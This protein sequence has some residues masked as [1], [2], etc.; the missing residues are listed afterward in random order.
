MP[1]LQGLLD[2]LSVIPDGSAL[3]DGRHHHDP[4]LDPHIPAT[5]AL[6]QPS[7]PRPLTR[8]QLHRP[9]FTSHHPCTVF[10]H[11]PASDTVLGTVLGKPRTSS[12]PTNDRAANNLFLVSTASTATSSTATCDQRCIPKTGAATEVPDSQQTSFNAAV[13]HESHEAAHA[14][15]HAAEAASHMDTAGLSDTEKRYL[16]EAKILSVFSIILSIGAA[17]LCFAGAKMELSCA[18]KLLKEVAGDF[19]KW[20]YSSQT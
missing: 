12:K 18:R 13:E 1:L 2:A 16:L 11:K 3:P 8:V 9:S 20:S 15:G 7:A 5:P 19:L 14:A 17:M 10:L 6:V 4:L